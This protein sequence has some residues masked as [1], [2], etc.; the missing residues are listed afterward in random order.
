MRLAGQST[1]HG[2][3]PEDVVR[4]RRS[5]RP[6][7]NGLVASRRSGSAAS[8]RRV[9]DQRHHA[10]RMKLAGPGRRCGSPRRPRRCPPVELDGRPACV[11]TTLIGSRTIVCSHSGFD[12][13]ALM[14]ETSWDPRS[15]A[16]SHSPCTGRW[17]LGRASET[18]TLLESSR[19]CCSTRHLEHRRSPRRTSAPG[20][21]NHVGHG[22]SHGASAQKTTCVTPQFGVLRTA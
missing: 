16:S 6:G 4:G 2:D 3:P 14:V 1:W 5:R 18:R 11:A 17:D 12:A 10:A 9:L 21:R 22:P 15:A 8:A 13:I 20:H 7:G 19:S